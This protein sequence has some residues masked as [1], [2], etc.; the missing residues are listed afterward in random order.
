VQIKREGEWPLAQY[1]VEIDADERQIVCS[2]TVPLYCDDPPP[3][4][5][6]NVQLTEI[7][8]GLGTSEHALGA[9]IF[10][11]VPTQLSVR[12]YEQGVELAQGTWAPLAQTAHPNGPQCPPACSMAPDVEL[13][14]PATTGER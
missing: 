5:A 10:A 9:I 4:D 1:R 13:L 6:H 11:E 12:L 8:C 7:G 3:C 2:T 14:L